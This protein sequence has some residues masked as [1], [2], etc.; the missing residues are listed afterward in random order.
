MQA[1]N[2]I[3]MKVLNCQLTDDGIIVSEMYTF[4]ANLKTMVYYVLKIKV[5]LNKNFWTTFFKYYI[6]F[7]KWHPTKTKRVFW[8]TVEC[9]KHVRVS[10][11]ELNEEI[12]EIC[13]NEMHAAI[14][15]LSWGKVFVVIRNEFQFRC[16]L[17][18]WGIVRIVTSFC[19]EIK[20]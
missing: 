3:M 9:L 19:L 18:R 16:E 8:W 15:K 10:D 6:I 5:K 7:G 20:N 2:S 13:V 12:P 4:W 11:D 14:R 1:K 17:V